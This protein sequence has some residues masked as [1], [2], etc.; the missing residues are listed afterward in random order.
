M[1]QEIIRIDLNSVNCY[2]GKSE[3]GFVLFDTGGP[4]TIDKSYTNRRSELE[5][6][7]EK[8]GCEPGNL[9]A[10]VITH[11]DNDHVANAAYLREKY[12]T[13]IA[14]HRADADLVEDL[15]L[16]KMMASFRYRSLILK[17][18]FFFLRKTIRE[19][20]ARSLKNFTKFSP[21][22]LLNDG[23]SLSQYGFDAEV[24]HLPGHTA[25]SIAVL[26]KEGELICGDTFA[27]MKKPA[28]A[29]N[30][31][32]FKL[33]KNSIEKLK[34]RNITMVYPGHGEPFPAKEL[35]I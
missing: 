16:D 8:A 5:E 19:I 30:A 28:P 6:Q 14:M 21:D 3:E 33:L 34:P 18:V 13:V 11:G 20:S 27:N 12:K 9:L 23:D 24:I 7:L 4:I 25:G 10:I 15:T 35:K 32:D 1:K 26:T 29:S 22:I 17:L 31:M 2:L